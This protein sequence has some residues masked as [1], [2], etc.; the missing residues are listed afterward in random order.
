MFV[1]Y[2]GLFL[3]IFILNLSEYCQEPFIW[4]QPNFEIYKGNIPVFAPVAHFINM[5]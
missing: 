3:M 1:L 5:D 4:W 2:C